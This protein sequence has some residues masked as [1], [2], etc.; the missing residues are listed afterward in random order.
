MSQEQGT[1]V[2]KV[3]GG[4]ETVLVVVVVVKGRRLAGVWGQSC[5]VAVQNKDVINCA[6][7]Y[8]ALDVGGQGM[9]IRERGKTHQLTAPY[10]V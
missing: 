5:R 9:E 3:E 7:P 4:A 6:E 2:V 10:G 8:L 1:G